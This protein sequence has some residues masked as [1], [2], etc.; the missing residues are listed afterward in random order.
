MHE[1]ECLVRTEFIEIA[2]L[3]CLIREKT[4]GIFISD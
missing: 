3:I 2:K 1:E 4:E